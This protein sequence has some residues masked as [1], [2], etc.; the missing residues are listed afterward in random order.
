MTTMTTMSNMY[1]HKCFCTLAACDEQFSLEADLYQLS[2]R[3]IGT[4]VYIEQYK[5]C[6]YLKYL[7]KCTMKLNVIYSKK[8]KAK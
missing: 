6:V 1:L 7:P 2:F 5:D 3:T 4:K 8:R